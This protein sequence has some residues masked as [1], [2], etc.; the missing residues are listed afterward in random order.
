MIALHAF[1]LIIRLKLIHA[2]NLGIHERDLDKILDKLANDQ[3]KEV[4]T[5]ESGEKREKQFHDFIHVSI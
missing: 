3:F 5:Y 2:E 4:C 1:E